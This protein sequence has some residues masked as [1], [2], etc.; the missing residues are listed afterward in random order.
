MVKGCR[1]WVLASV[2][3][4]DSHSSNGLSALPREAQGSRV[5]EN[6]SAPATPTL[7]KVLPTLGKGALPLVSQSQKYPC[8]PM[9]KHAS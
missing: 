3:G 4:G 1:R 7:Q 9:Q 2:K 6:S 8:K 5:K